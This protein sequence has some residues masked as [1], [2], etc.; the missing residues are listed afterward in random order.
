MWNDRTEPR[1]FA[2]GLNEAT[3][4]LLAAAI[5]L[6]G[7]VLWSSRGPNVEKT[8]FSL[9]YVGARIVHEGLGSRLYDI[10]FQKQIR[11]SLFEHPNPLFFE[12][13]PF[14]AFLLSPLGA[15]PFRSAYMIWGLFNALVWLTMM[16]LLRPWLPWPREDL[17][18][19]CLW[20]LFA[21]VGVA[22]FQGQSSI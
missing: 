19:I 7:A 5:L 10:N 9:T 17:G 21:P 3:M 8:D 22:I 18:Y 4:G 14:E 16:F 20:F 11:D 13:P 2:L 6:V 12:H 15:I 1:G